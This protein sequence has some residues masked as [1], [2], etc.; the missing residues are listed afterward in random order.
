MED[1]KIYYV[2]T[3]NL[4]PKKAKEYLEK[5]VKSFKNIAR[6]RIKNQNK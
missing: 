3:G 4:S 6:I 5:V 2:E 1:R